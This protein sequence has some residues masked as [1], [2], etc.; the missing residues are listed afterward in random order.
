MVSRD[1]QPALPR[2]EAGGGKSWTQGKLAIVCSGRGRARTK[3][4]GTEARL[5]QFMSAALNHAADVIHCW[6][7]ARVLLCDRHDQDM[8][9][10]RREIDL[11]RSIPNPV[12][13]C[14]TVSFRKR[15]CHR[16][17]C[18]YFPPIADDVF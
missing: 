5:M 1:V 15:D 18:L 11:A 2:D 16:R 7:L 9:P 14:A 6:M 4:T 10:H 8:L 17:V 12:K 13:S 3:A